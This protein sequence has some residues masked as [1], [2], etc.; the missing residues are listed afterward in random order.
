MKPAGR[1]TVRFPSKHD[2]HPPKGYKNW[3]EVES[4]TTKNG[5][6]RDRRQSKKDIEKDN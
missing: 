2:D 3:W 1:H 6:N 4:D 5:K